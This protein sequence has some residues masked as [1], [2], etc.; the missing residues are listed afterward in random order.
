MPE[1]ADLSSSFATSQVE[2][3]RTLPMDIENMGFLLDRLG[4]DCAPLQFLRELTVNSIEAIT[5]LPDKKGDIVWE[6]DWNRYDLER[7]YKLCLIDTGIG[8][9]GPE[10]VKYINHLSSSGGVQ[11]VEGNFGVGAKISAATTNHAG[12][13]YLSWKDGKGAMI[14]LWR[15]PDTGTYG[16]RQLGLPGGKFNHW[17]PVDDALRPKHISDHGTMV[18]LLGNDPEDDTMK[19]PEGTPTPSRWVARY[20][21]M[22]F[23]EFP[24]GVTVRAREGWTSENPDTNVLRM[25]KGSKEFLERY[26]EASGT[27]DLVDAVAHWWIL[28]DLNAIGQS[29]GANLPGGHVAALHQNELYELTAG[30]AG[31]ARLQSFGVYVGHQRVVI[32]VQPKNGSAR[33]VT[34][35][36]ARTMLVMNGEPLPWGEWAERFRERFPSEIKDFMDTVSHERQS[37]DHKK[38]ILDRLQEIEDLLRLKKYKPNTTGSLRISEEMTLGTSDIGTGTRKRRSGTGR[39]AGG[40]RRD[41]DLYTLFLVEEGG[42]SGDEVRNRFDIDVRWVPEQE[43]GVKDRAGRYIPETKMLLINQ[44]FRVFTGFIERWDKRYKGVPGA[45]VIVTEVVREWFEQTLRE[46]IYSVDFLRGDKE[47]TDEDTSRILSEEALTAAILPRYH[48]EM[49]VRRTLGSKLGSNKEKIA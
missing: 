26:K 45:R 5:R 13:I 30:R 44:D 8:M 42:Q 4:T 37:P 7:T 27:V 32:Y 34:A 39:S 17:G 33:T 47:W 9:T 49:A 23:F 16:L 36:T 22:R 1:S 18:I 14:H 46:V 20:L 24:K 11:S 28:N 10:M 12:V 41:G 25:V 29:S 21:N 38:S 15:N 40:G 35:N 31:S 6:V 43:V 19:A 48:T 2:S 3:E